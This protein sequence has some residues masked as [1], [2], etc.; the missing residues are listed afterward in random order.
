MQEYR[1]THANR[2]VEQFKFVNHLPEQ[3]MLST[4]RFKAGTLQDFDWIR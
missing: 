3:A 2:L 1:K 4:K